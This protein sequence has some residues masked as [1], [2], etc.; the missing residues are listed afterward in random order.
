[1][2]KKKNITLIRKEYLLDKLNE[3]SINKDPFKQ[4]NIWFDQAIN[5]KIDEPNAMTL[6]TA[7]KNGLPSARIVLLKDFNERGFTFFTNYKSR[8]G[9]E[10]L[11]NP[12]A[13][14]VFFWKE[15]ERQV[16]IEGLVEKLSREES[17][18]YFKQRSFE[19]RIGSIASKQS[20]IVPDREYLEDKFEMLKKEYAGKNP[21]MPFDWGGFLVIP[22]RFEFWQGRENRLHDRIGYEKSGSDWK[23]YRLSP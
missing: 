7:D 22:F 21:L 6:A 19:S 20:E 3:E 5:S 11:Q 1:M 14:L 16:R 17:E 18:E 10:L 9:R 2:V 4:F 15:L 13:Y 23:I 12:H 8:K